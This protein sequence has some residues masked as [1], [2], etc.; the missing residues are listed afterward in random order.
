LILVSARILGDVFARM[1]IPSVLG[2]LSAGILLGVSGVGL[3][4]VK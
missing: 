1:G 2:E 3:I 4:E